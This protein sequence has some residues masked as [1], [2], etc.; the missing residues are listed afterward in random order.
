V[1]RV[2]DGPPLWIE[3]ASAR[4]DVNG[5]AISAHSGFPL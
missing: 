1:Q 4:D 3:N 2:S 5:D